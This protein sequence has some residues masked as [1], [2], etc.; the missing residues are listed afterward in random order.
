MNIGGALATPGQMAG[1]MT[2][3]RMSGYI[4]AGTYSITSATPNISNGCMTP[5]TRTLV[6]GYNTTRAF[7]NTDTK[8]VIQTNVSTATQIGNTDAAFN[9]IDFDG[10][11]ATTSAHV[12]TNARFFNCVVRN[13]NT[14]SG[15]AH[16]FSC[17]LTGN[18]IANA[19]QGAFLFTE[20]YAN[21][22]T[23]IFASAYAVNV[24]TYDNTGASTDGITV[25]GP[26]SAIN[27]TA[28]GNGRDGIV[29]GNSGVIITAVNCVAQSNGRYGLRGDIDVI[30]VNY[31]SY[32]NTSGSTNGYVAAS[33]NPEAYSA[34]AFT[35]TANDNYALNNIAS[36]GAALRAQGMAGLLATF[37]RGLTSGY[38]DI[39]AAQHA[40]PASS[41]GYVPQVFE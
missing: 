27:I 37:P 32:N 34:D 22:A 18:S 6:I 12:N 21:T 28:I 19:C 23:P 5:T 1:L 33:V 31:A 7:G 13:F 30:L 11:N 14:T 4:K 10:N 20:A 38:L 40:D 8:P 29:I 24:L 25:Q 3:A 16:Y 41:G 17:L 35:D 15:T 39:G 9:N 36:A 2:V 26:S